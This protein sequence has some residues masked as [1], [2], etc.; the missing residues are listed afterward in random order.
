VESTSAEIRS[1]IAARTV[2]DLLGDRVREQE[3][4]EMAEYMSM[5]AVVGQYAVVRVI[6]ADSST[7]R[8]VAVGSATI[9][10]FYRLHEL[11]RG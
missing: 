9:G 1:S 5:D 6:R 3:V 11:L 7:L 2:F 4:S 8:G 10:D